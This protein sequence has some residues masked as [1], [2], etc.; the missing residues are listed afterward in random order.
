MC[1]PNQE[2]NYLLR[3]KITKNTTHNTTKKKHTNKSSLSHLIFPVSPC[4]YQRR[5]QIHNYLVCKFYSVTTFIPDQCVWNIY[6]LTHVKSQARNSRCIGI[7]CI[8]AKLL[9]C[10]L[11]TLCMF[12]FLEDFCL[13][14]IYYIWNSFI[15]KKAKVTTVFYHSDIFRSQNNYLV[16]MG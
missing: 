15:S 3:F 2:G 9:S 8:R 10:H 13:P 12:L 4:S 16:I 6:C 5:E 14:K 11:I 1:N 7:Y